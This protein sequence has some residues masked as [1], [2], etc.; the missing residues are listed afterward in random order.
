ME[1]L[2]KLKASYQVCV[3]DMKTLL[4]GSDEFT[5]EQQA[6]FDKLKAK[7]E[8]LKTQISNHEQ[9][10]KEEAEADRMVESP[11]LDRQVKPDSVVLDDPVKGTKNKPFTVPARAKRWSGN[12]KS[13]KGPD[14]DVLAYKAGMWL[15][16]TLCNNSYARN[17]CKTHGIATDRV[18]FEQTQ[19]EALH[20]EGVNA[21]GGYLVFDEYENSIIRLVEEYGI[22]RKKM[23]TVP[24]MS[25]VKIQPRRTGGLTAY[26]V[27]EGA[28]ITESTGSWDNVKLVAKKLAAITTASNELLSDA[29]ISIADE[30]TREIALAFATK[31]D[32]CGFQGNG[33][34]TYGGI[35]G[36]VQK[37][38]TINGVNDG[39]GLSLGANNTYAEVTDAEL[40][41]LVGM[42]PNFPGIRPEWYCSKT[43]WAQVM[44]RLIRATGGATMAEME[45][46]NVPMY[47]GYPVNWTSG[48][49]AMPVA[50]ANSQISCLFGDF[51]MAAHFGDRAGIS[52]ATSVDAT[53]GSTS[54]FDTDSFA[55]RGVERFDINVHDVGTSTAAGPVV[56]FIQAAS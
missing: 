46:K 19:V 53:V 52:I 8:S 24:M 10:I 55:I 7:A 25:D 47:A 54:V 27:G 9:V 31:E 41:K 5:D 45:G 49:T 18:Q 15:A 39:G 17:F 44:V 30:A 26:F 37:L 36:V 23:K 11:V 4:D 34:S 14:A 28:S 48:T 6:E 38:S 56:G 12:L 51:G 21:S 32:L 33:T 3:D 43:F 20:Q 13:F 40:M 50:V 2:K 1:K 22:V 29:I 35:V 42:I 16:A